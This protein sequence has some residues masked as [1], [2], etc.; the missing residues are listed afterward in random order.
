MLGNREG[1]AGMLEM[2]HSSSHMLG[3]NTLL[4]KSSYFKES[5]R[6]LQSEV[7]LLMKALHLLSAVC[8]IE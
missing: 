4:R 6:A 1:S 8:I 5:K 3:F 2:L 7:E